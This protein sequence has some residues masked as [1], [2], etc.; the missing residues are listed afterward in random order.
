[1]TSPRYALPIEFFILSI[2]AVN[3]FAIDCTKAVVAICVEF[4]P[5][6][7]V[8]AVGVPVRLGEFLSALPAKSVCNPCISPCTNAVVA[9]LVE[10]S[11]ADGVTA[12]GVP[13]NCG[14]F[15]SAFSDC[16]AAISASIF[17]KFSSSTAMSSV[18]AG[19]GSFNL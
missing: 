3:S 16:S 8:G 10:L 19:S 6:A 2:C 4:V 15:L 1:M 11:D 13:V 14:E 12:F 17:I 5:L 7:A 9:I 18:S